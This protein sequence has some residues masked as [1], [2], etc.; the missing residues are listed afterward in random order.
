MPTYR[1]PVLESFEWQG[2]VEDKD[3][4]APPGSPTKGVRYIVK[5]TGTGAWAGHDNEITY[6]DGAAWQFMAEAE[7]QICWVKDENLFYYFDGTSWASIST[8]SGGGKSKSQAFTASG[9]W[10]CP[11]GVTLVWVTAVGGGG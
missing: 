1:V 6:Y 11:T 8:G 5:A 4:S 9:T 7:G 10:N 2:P 3:L